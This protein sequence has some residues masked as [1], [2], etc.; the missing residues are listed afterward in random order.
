[1]SQEGHRTVFQLEQGG[2]SV[3]CG[4]AVCVSGLLKLGWKLSD[5]QQLSVLVRA[6]AAGP[7]L[8]THEPSD[9][10]K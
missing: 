5:P 9:H 1:M 10:F 4:S 6:L 8:S 7:Q 3:Y 2:R